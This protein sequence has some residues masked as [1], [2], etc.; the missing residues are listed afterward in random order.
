[1]AIVTPRPLAVILGEIGFGR[2][3]DKE[4]AEEAVASI[5]NSMKKS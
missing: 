5:E 3:V 1:M 4:L 2:R